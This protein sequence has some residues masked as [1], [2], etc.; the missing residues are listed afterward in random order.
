[1]Q[2][3]SHLNTFLAQVFTTMLL[4]NSLPTFKPALRVLCS[5]N[6]LVQV[7]SHFDICLAAKYLQPCCCADSFPLVLSIPWTLTKSMGSG[8][9]LCSRLGA[10]R[11]VTHGVSVLT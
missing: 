1:V 9:A 7:S 10:W 2:V 3:S 11:G 5:Y 8:R 6:A 4:Y